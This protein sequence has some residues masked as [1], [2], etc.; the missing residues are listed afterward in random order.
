MR[1]GYYPMSTQH[2][3]STHNF[4]HCLY[5]FVH[6]EMMYT[7]QY[8]N[9]HSLQHKFIFN[10]YYICIVYQCSCV[11]PQVDIQHYK[12]SDIHQLCYGKYVDTIQV[13][14]THLHLQYHIQCINYITTIHSYQYIT[15]TVSFLCNIFTTVTTRTLIGTFCVCTN[16]FTWSGSIVAFI[17]IYH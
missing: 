8:L 15:C 16:V 12:Y 14:H 13:W 2:H 6:M 10:C 1:L 11:Y 3:M 5:I 17:D 4:L 7:H 9:T